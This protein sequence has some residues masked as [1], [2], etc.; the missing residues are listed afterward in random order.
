[1]I[2]KCALAY[3]TT[4][5]NNIL[6]AQFKLYQPFKKIKFNFMFFNNPF[7]LN[8][9]VTHADILARGKVPSKK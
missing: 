3:S 7:F 6:N 2:S 9:T 4:L 5:S 1:M 8:F